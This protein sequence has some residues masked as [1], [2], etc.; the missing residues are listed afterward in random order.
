MSCFTDEEIARI[1]ESDPDLEEEGV[2][3]RTPD[4]EFDMSFLLLHGSSPK[5][6]ADLE[7]SLTPTIDGTIPD[8]EPDESE[9]AESANVAEPHVAL[10]PGITAENIEN[11]RSYFE[12]RRIGNPNSFVHTAKFKRMVSRAPCLAKETLDKYDAETR[13]ARFHDAAMRGAALFKALCAEDDM[14]AQNGGRNFDA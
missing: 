6:T 8:L 1:L 13:K 2:T 10:P 9:P 7:A 12:V 14:R 3:A 5:K 11:A 4:P